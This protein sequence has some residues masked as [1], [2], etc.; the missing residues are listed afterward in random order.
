MGGI[1]AISMISLT[2]LTSYA[3]CLVRTSMRG[4]V[5]GCMTTM[6]SLTEVFGPPVFGLLMANTVKDTGASWWVVNSPFGVGV[7]CVVVSMVLML[8]LPHLSKA[9]QLCGRTF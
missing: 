4:E 7:L 2:A 9:M 5:Q 1:G 6:V 8:R 3:G